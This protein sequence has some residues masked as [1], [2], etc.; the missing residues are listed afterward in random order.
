MESLISDHAMN[1]GKIRSV[2]DG[3]VIDI[4]QL[5]QQAI[6]SVGECKE[7]LTNH[8]RRLQ[9][10]EGHKPQVF[11][12]GSPQAAQMP[13]GI[14]ADLPRDE[15]G[16]RF[17]DSP[18]KRASASPCLWWYLACIRVVQPTGAEHRLPAG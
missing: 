8:E 7:Q 10:L 3:A 13:S 14:G 11:H 12:G 4:Q 16:V 15:Q 17:P 18:L 2:A 9:M 6:T 1:L 5:K